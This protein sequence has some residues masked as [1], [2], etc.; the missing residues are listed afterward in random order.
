MLAEQDVPEE[1]I[2]ATVKTAVQ[3][4][5]VTPVF[6]GSAYKNKGVQPLLDAVVPL[7]A[8]AAGT[9]IGPRLSTIRTEE[10]PALCRS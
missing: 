10:F 5:D 1:L 8:V 6:M 7:F 2:H 4:Q 3:G 9:A